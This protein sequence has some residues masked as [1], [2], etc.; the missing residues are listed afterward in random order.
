MAI[1]AQIA[2]N[3]VVTISLGSHESNDEEGEAKKDRLAVA[4]S[5]PIY[6]LSTTQPHQLICVFHR[7]DTCIFG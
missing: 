1:S 2:V 5:N 4:S 3:A 7:I 6:L